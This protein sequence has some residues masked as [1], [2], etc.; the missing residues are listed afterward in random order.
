MLMMEHLITQ[1]VAVVVLVQL[2]KTDKQ[3]VMVLVEMV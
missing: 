3:L 1:V 2:V